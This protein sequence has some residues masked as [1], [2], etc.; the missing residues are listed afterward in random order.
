MVV[1]ALQPGTVNIEP[2]NP[3]VSVSVITDCSNQKCHA[4]ACRVG[5][6]KEREV[7]ESNSCDG[8]RNFFT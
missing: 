2:L 1:R 5:V 6:R 3:G 8:V 7:N 4:P